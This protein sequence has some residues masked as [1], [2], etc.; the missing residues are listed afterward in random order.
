MEGR[1]A[2]FALPFDPRGPAVLVTIHTPAA[3]ARD[4]RLHS[5]ALAGCLRTEEPEA[6]HVIRGSGTIEETNQRGGEAVLLVSCG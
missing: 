6:G 3:M 1:L 5:P 2:I 4:L